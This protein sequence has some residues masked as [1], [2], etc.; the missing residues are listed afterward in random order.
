MVF[1][2]FLKYF[3]EKA[4]RVENDNR[5]GELTILAMFLFNV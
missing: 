1:F 5:I 3:K 2:V 4:L